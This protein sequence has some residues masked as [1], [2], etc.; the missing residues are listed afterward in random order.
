MSS[1]AIVGGGISGLSAAYYLSKAG[2]SSTLIEAR[3]RLGGV[4]Q[5]ERIQDCVVEAGPDSFLSVKPWAMDLLREL[6]L[7]GEVI[8]SNDHQRKTFIRRRGRMVELPD[9][10]QMLV[11]T[12]ILPMA[13]S[14]LL[15]WPSKF[16]MALEYFRRPSSAPDRDRS[17]AEFVEEHYG[18]EAVDYLAEPLL[19]GIY[20]GDPGELS[21]ESVLPR[22]VGLEQKYGSLTRGVLAER[23]AAK[24]PRAPLFRTLRGGLG[25][26]IEALSRAIAERTAFIHRPVEI[27]ERTESGFRLRAAGDWLEAQCVILACEAHRAAPLIDAVD[28]RMAA[29]LGSI[30]YS[31]SITVALGFDRNAVKNQMHGFGFLVPKRERRKL[32]AAT[33]VG[34]KFPNRVPESMALLRCFLGGVGGE[35]TMAA[36]D[37]IV[38]A[39]VREELRELVAIIAEPLFWRVYRW[40]RSMAQYT[41]GHGERIR[42]LEAQLRLIPGLLVAGNAYHGIGVPDCIR[43]G[44]EAAVRVVGAAAGR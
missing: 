12:K 41:V 10:V 20:G 2:I 24:G 33:W 13:A 22:F 18:R 16:R 32:L 29:V 9:G 44:K 19:A 42:E 39:T 36:S 38:V 40:P 28:G 37:D 21:V 1:V 25:T 11:P 14:P 34:N 43:M 7:E 27:V 5:T 3:P 8:G 23:A 30:G 17:V 35:A 4:I 15:S 26:M 31:S 6:G